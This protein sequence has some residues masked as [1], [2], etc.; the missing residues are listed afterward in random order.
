M[1]KKWMKLRS[2]DRLE[3]SD[4]HKLGQV[5]NECKEERTVLYM[6]NADGK[7]V[8]VK[9]HDFSKFLSERD[10]IMLQRWTEG[11]RPEHCVDPDN[12]EILAK[13][14]EDAKKKDDDGGEAWLEFFRR[15]FKME[16]R[17]DEIDKWCPAFKPR[18][19]R[20]GEEAKREE[21]KAWY[22]KAP[23]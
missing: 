8:P 5:V 6:R 4:G 3:D 9:M 7:V 18:L 2:K 10:D 17:Q 11:K 15:K 23:K 12:P 21:T 1:S 22:V 14:N 16:P 19:N 13:Y 20:A